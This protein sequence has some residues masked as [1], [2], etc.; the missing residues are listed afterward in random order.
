MEETDRETWCLIDDA[1]LTKD[2]I[3]VGAHSDPLTLSRA[4]DRARLGQGDLISVRALMPHLWELLRNLRESADMY[5]VA[6][7]RKFRSGH[8][9]RKL[10][11]YQA[12]QKETATIRAI[13]GHP[14]KRTSRAYAWRSVAAALR[15]AVGASEDEQGD[16]AAGALLWVVLRTIDST[17]ACWYSG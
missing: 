15:K 10:N 12:A 7:P 3:P 5:A 13:V 16:L 6:N 9:G 11:W 4:F 1:I 14:S 2:Q 17:F 8:Q